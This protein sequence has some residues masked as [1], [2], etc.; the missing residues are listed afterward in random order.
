MIITVRSGQRLSRSIRGAGRVVVDVGKAVPSGN[1]V[2]GGYIH[3][4]ISLL[5]RKTR[6][7]GNHCYDGLNYMV[8]LYSDGKLQVAVSPVLPDMTRDMRGIN[9]P[10]GWLAGVLVIYEGR[11]PDIG[12]IVF[13]IADEKLH[14]GGIT[15]DLYRDYSPSQIYCSGVP[16]PPVFNGYVEILV[17]GVTVTPKPVSKPVAR[18]A[19]KPSVTSKPVPSYAKLLLPLLVIGGVVYLLG[20]KKK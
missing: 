1:T 14:V 16:S 8:I 15:I 18:R 9:K 11:Y 12:K 7:Y 3:Y 5:D 2:Y 13:D 17:E 20:R 10:L 6:C 4:V 19:V